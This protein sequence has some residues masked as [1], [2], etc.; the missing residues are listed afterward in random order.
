MKNA[1]Y[2]H[3]KG[4]GDTQKQCGRGSGALVKGHKSSALEVG[5]PVIDLL[6]SYLQCKARL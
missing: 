6:T 1:G 5:V 3:A 4:Y 2:G